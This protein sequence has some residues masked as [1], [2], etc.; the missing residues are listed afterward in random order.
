MA[1]LSSSTVLRHR[2]RVIGVGTPSNAPH[3]QG[4][5]EWGVRLLPSSHPLL[6]TPFLTKPPPERG[7]AVRGRSLHRRLGGALS[8]GSSGVLIKATI[9]GKVAHTTTR[10]GLTARHRRRATRRAPLFRRTTVGAADGIRCG[11]TINTMMFSNRRIVKWATSQRVPSPL[12]APQLSGATSIQGA[13]WARPREAD[14][15]AVRVGTATIAPHQ[16][17]VRVSPMA[18]PLVASGSGKRRRP[19][20]PLSRS[21]TAASLRRDPVPPRRSSTTGTAPPLAT[22]TSEKMPT[23]GRRAM[24][25]RA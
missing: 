22:H 14:R 5:R 18:T 2:D 3:R 23:K 10:R 1:G 6:L 17:P 24:R 12:K 4:R 15:E 7:E 8:L 9:Q 11:V 19:F 25:S 13:P 20:R 21:R 16:G